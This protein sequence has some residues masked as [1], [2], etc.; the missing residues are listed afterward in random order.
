MYSSKIT[1]LAATVAAG[2]LL[3]ISC[4]RDNIGAIYEGES[5]FAFA[6]GVLNVESS[7]EDDN[8]VNVPIL[9]GDLSRSIAEISIEYDKSAGSNQPEWTDADPEGIFT[10]MSKRVVFADESFSSYIRIH[11]SSLEALGISEKH[12]LRLTIK[13]GVSPSGRNQVIVT[14]SRKLTFIKY[15]ECQYFDE[16]M[17]FNSYKAE[18]YK[19]EEAEIYRVTNPYTQGLLEEEYADM[20]WMDNAPS[21]VEFSVRDDNSIYFKPFRTGMKVNGLYQTYCYY[22]SE[23]QWGRDF[24]D[25]DIQ[26][27]KLSDKHF[28][29]CA[30]YCLPDFQY[31][32]L[33]EGAYNID[34]TVQ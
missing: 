30:V 2:L 8:T 6:S 10:L 19:A 3:L 21:Y 23:Y 13:D 28:Q 24:S 14:V 32:Y 16:C 27:Q 9:R 34:I 18:I 1:L 20:G 12:R 7:A 17:F 11:F 31:G 15:G 4:N 33:N 5:G 29:L 26:N 22:P 25:Y